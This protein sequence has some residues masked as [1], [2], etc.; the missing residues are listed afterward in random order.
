MS[1]MRGIIAVT[2]TPFKEDGKIDYESAEKHINW[3]LESGVHGLL[4]VGATGEFAALSLEERKELAEFVMKTVAGRVPVMIGVVSQTLEVT[5]ELANHAASI[6]ADSVMV[7]PA[8]GLHLSQEEIYQYYKSVSE[9]V[10]IS[11][12][13]YNNPGS[14]GVAIDPDTLER[15]ATLPKMTYLKE[16]TGDMVSVTR[17]LDSVGDKLTV[18]CGCESLAYESFVMGAKGW[19]C[20]GANYAPAMCVELFDRIVNK[21]DLVGARDI[22]RK[23]LPMLRLTEESGELWQVAKYA[24][25]KHG[26]GNGKLRL[27]RL[28]VSEASKKAVDGVWAANKL[29]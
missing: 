22:Y 15:I 12:M 18:F 27:P 17:A 29:S 13:V 9:N 23:L 28:P 21:G 19:I 4:P 5:I 10:N 14:A 3:L 6:G 2:V 26:I 20:V 1:N 7:L 8:P 25:Q 16:S 11:I 24:L